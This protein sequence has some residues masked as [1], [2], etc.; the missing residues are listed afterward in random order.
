MPVG[1]GP[2]VKECTAGLDKRNAEKMSHKSPASIPGESPLY[3][4]KCPPHHTEF[5]Q[6]THKRG[7]IS[8]HQK[9]IQ[10]RISTVTHDKN[11]GLI[12]DDRTD[13][14]FGY[15]LYSK[16]ATSITH[17]HHPWTITVESGEFGTDMVLL[18]ELHTGPGMG[19]TWTANNVYHLNNYMYI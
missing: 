5:P 16:H 2:T 4:L 7:R 14:H 19:Y 10:V 11:E 13:W 12:Y 6:W 9:K 18:E 17:L 1:L 3:I 15:Q 8:N